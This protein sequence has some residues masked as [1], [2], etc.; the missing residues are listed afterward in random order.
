MKPKNEAD[1]QKSLGADTS[2]CPIES[3]PILINKRAYEL[4]EQRG[5]ESGHEM[6]DWLRAESEIKHHLNL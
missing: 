1:V 6:E 3:L 2:G 5:R 4:F